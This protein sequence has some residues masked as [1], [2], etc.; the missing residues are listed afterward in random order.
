MIE[1]RNLAGPALL[2]RSMHGSGSEPLPPGLVIAGQD[3]LH[4]IDARDEQ[5]V[6]VLMLALLRAAWPSIQAQ[7]Q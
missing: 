7:N 2:C 3:A 6:E 4:E 1:P 5:H